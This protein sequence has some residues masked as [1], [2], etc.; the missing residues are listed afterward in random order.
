MSLHYLR[1]EGLS[2]CGE[3]IR[4]VCVHGCRLLQQL[5][6]TSS[7]PNKPLHIST[8][9]PTV[10]ETGATT[11]QRGMQVVSFFREANGTL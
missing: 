10:L 4:M 5:Q 1:G 6:T 2:V 3:A 9:R 7:A 8:L 11:R